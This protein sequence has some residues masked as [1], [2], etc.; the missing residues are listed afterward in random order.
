[1]ASCVYLFQAMII[2][3]HIRL[4]NDSNMLVSVIH[5]SNVTAIIIVVVVVVVL[6]SVV[7]ARSL[8]R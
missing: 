1:M 4:I 6:G 8:E 2:S 5:A 3:T 7:T